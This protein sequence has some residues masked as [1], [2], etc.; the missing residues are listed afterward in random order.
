MSQTFLGRA[1][2]DIPATWEDQSVITFVKGDAKTPMNFMLVRDNLGGQD[3]ASY[4]RMQ[5]RAL[6]KEIA[7]YKLVSEDGTDSAYRMEHSFKAPEGNGR[8]HQ[9]QV[10]RTAGDDVYCINITCA[11]ADV[12]ANRAEID[13][14]ISS[15]QVT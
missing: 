2:I 11:S 5:A 8:V 15:F 12:D 6:K 7:D 4:A 10:L 13:A 1:R 14:I 3:V 9:I